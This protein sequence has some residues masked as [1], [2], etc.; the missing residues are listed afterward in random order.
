MSPDGYPVPRNWKPSTWEH[1]RAQAHKMVLDLRRLMLVKDAIFDTEFE[2][3]CKVITEP[4]ADGNFN[5]YDSDGVECQFNIEM[6][7]GAPKL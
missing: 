7:R 5:A 1:K 4:D 2:T 6:V 3:G